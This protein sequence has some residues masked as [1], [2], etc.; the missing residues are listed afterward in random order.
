[1]TTPRDIPT[2]ITQL[3][4]EKMKRNDTV[5]NAL[6]AFL[7]LGALACTGTALAQQVEKTLPPS[8]RITI[9]LSAG[10]AINGLS[11]CR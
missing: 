5:W 6:V 1:V 2:V 3:A 10:G 8:D 7:V 11:R 4:R 9:D